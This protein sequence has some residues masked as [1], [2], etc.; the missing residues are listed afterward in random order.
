MK[1]H[2]AFLLSVLI[3]GAA[4]MNIFAQESKSEAEKEVVAVIQQLFD[5]MRAADSTAVG[6]TFHP[7]A[8]MQTVVAK[9]GTIKLH[10]GSVEKFLTAIGTP[11]EEIYNEV[12]HDYDVRIDGELASV[13]TPYTFKLGENISHCGVNAFQ[14]V[15]LDGKWLILQVTDTR[16]KENCQ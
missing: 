4:T 13:W 15:K 7:D 3:W 12:I 11:H 6:K 2:I 16:H 10:T 14:L 1:N 8:R 9:E 5:G